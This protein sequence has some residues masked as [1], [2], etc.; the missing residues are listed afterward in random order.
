MKTLEFWCENVNKQQSLVRKRYKFWCENVIFV[1][2]KFGV[3]TLT[4]GVKTRAELLFIHFPF[5]KKYNNE[6]EKNLF[7]LYLKLVFT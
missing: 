1:V 3:K 5:S 4:F 7:F 6:K 2:S